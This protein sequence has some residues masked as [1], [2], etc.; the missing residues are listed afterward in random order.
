MLPSTA[1][2]EKKRAVEFSAIPF[3]GSSRD[4]SAYKMSTET[5]AP[6]ATSSTT[7]SLSVPM[8]LSQR[9]VALKPAGSVWCRGCA[10]RWGSW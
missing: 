2:M 8:A 5:A 3:G 9:A 6:A 10:V 4:E 1:D 7:V